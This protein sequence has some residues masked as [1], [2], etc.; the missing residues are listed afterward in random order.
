VKVFLSG[1]GPDEL[2]DW[3]RLPQHRS[4]PPVMGLLEAL[5]CKIGAA[6]V[7]V[8]GARI[9]KS[10]NKYRFK[11]PVRGEVQNVL[12]LVLEAEEAGAEALVFVR[13]QDGYQDRQDDVEEGIRQAR[14]RGY[15][16][17]IV[18]GVAVQEIEAW[19][20][21]LLGERRSEGHADAKAVLAK[22]HEIID[23]A[24]KVAVVE[25]ADLDRVPEDARSLRAWLS[26]AGSAFAV[27]G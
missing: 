16:P 26:E 4:S 10:I 20:L 27:K 2:G 24:G 3:F 8:A 18:G 1:E 21:A 17:K 15:A 6:G 23:R 9:W 7:D 5:L 11:P 12:G 13:D 22:K 14:E 25:G 19:I